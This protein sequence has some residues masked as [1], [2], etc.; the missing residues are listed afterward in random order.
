MNPKK[1]REWDL[2]KPGLESI[3]VQYKLGFKPS[4]E[5]TL[6]QGNLDCKTEA[7][8]MCMGFKVG[9]KPTLSQEEWVEERRKIRNPEFAPSSSFESQQ[10]G[11]RNIHSISEFSNLSTSR[12]R[13]ENTQYMIDPNE[14]Y[15][16]Q[17]KDSRSPNLKCTESPLKHKE[18]TLRYTKNVSKYSGKTPKY[19]ENS[20][21]F[22]SKHT[23]SVT[24]KSNDRP[25]KFAPPLSYEYFHSTNTPRSKTR[26]FPKE[27]TCVEEAIEK[28]LSSMRKQSG[29]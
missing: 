26:L 19:T 1:I 21:E 4:E 28:G 20:S 18:K 3:S 6:T 16:K 25:L 9:T 22:K 14:E 8:L 2:G 15:T 17:Y 12:Y 13:S 11:S 27:T 7:G 24:S 5:Q 29:P 23:E 10:E